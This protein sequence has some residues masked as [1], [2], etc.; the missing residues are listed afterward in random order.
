MPRGF[1]DTISRGEIVDLFA[2]LEAAHPKESLPPSG[3][4]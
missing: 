2:F 1:L 3:S 4:C